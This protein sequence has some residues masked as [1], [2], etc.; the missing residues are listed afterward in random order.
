[1]MFFNMTAWAWTGSYNPQATYQ[2]PALVQQYYDTHPNET[3]WSEPA[4]AALFVAKPP[5]TT[6]G[7]NTM[8]ISPSVPTSSSSSAPPSTGP[9]HHSDTG[10]IVGG[11]VGG[12]AGIAIVFA[13]IFFC[14]A[15]RR[16]RQHQTEHGLHPASPAQEIGPSDQK[17]ELPG[18]A[19]Q[20]K[21]EQ[22]AVEL[23]AGHPQP[24]RP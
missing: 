3:V 5:S 9:K 2:R 13:V 22:N 4:L 23:P 20:M 21:M 8:S 14:L 18:R 10:A 15:I 12:V 24:N 16:R 19:Q 7:T 17:Y 6:T 1:M 11:V